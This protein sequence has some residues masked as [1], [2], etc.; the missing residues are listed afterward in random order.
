MR[1]PDSRTI[2]FFGFILS[3]ILLSSAYYM[4][5]IKGL[6]PCSLCVW[7][8]WLLS[9]EGILFLGAAFQNPASRGIQ[10]YAFFTL[11]FA[12]FG[13]IAS[14]RQLWLHQT[15]PGEQICTTA[16]GHPPATSLVNGLRELFIGV[17]HCQPV[18]NWEMFGLS[19]PM[20]MLVIF[21]VLAVL[22]ILQLT[23]VNS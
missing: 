21:I 5:I 7:Q 22:S 8:R 2:N 17:P 3:V 10:I 11:L 12:V 4:Q 19:I 16:A 6:E 1:I 18:G 15:Y 20:L 9:L 23:R 14:G 13:I